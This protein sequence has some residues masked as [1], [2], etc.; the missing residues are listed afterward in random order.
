MLAAVSD[1][2]RGLVESPCRCV[3]GLVT[4][5]GPIVLP[6]RWDPAGSVVVER[7]LLHR[8]DA[9]LPG[10]CAV[11][12]DV[13]DDRRPTAKAGVMLRG[14]AELLVARPGIPDHGQELSVR[15]RRATSW[16]GFAVTT[17][18]AS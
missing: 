7:A 9:T 16:A 15:V 1:E 8:A 11:T 12:I 17:R 3:V 14:D 4:P 18:Q 13:S 6:G 5:S 2:L 10:R